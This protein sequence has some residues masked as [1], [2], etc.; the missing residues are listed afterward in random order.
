MSRDLELHPLR[1]R[2]IFKEKIWGGPELKRVMGKKG[3][4]ARTGESWEIAHRGK[5]TSV[6]AEGPF[7]GWT[8]EKLMQT[9]P[10]QILGDDHAMRFSGRFPL[11][12][13]FLCAHDRLSLQVHPSDDYA[14]RYEPEPFGK[15]EAWYILHAPKDARVVRGVLPGTTVAEFRQH[16]QTGTVDQCLNQMEVQESDV[17]FL[18]PGT[19]HTAFGGLV[20]LEVQQNSDVTY[21]LHDWGRKERNGHR[22]LNLERAMIVTDF[23]S[24]G[25]SKYKPSRM[26]GFPYRRNLL[27]KCEKF[28]MEALVLDR[29]RIKDSVP[30]TRFQVLTVTRGKGKF[31]FGEQKRERVAW[32]KGDTFLIPAYLGEYDI[33]SEAS[34]ELVCTYVE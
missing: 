24:M 12:I 5:D 17:I 8:L 16:L 13:K 3:A 31:F 27:I 15:M 4:G 33:A 7:K 26:L 2:E 29:R 25:V 22:S 28:T 14:Q 21:R 20:M 34:S 9:W 19:L 11:L 32:K 1:F 18:P 23:Y 10:K 6:V 30:R